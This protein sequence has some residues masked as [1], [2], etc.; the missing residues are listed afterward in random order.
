ML[1]LSVIAILSKLPG[2]LSGT[3]PVPRLFIRQYAVAV[4]CSRDCFY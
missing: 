3:Q 4:V 2:A 1:Q